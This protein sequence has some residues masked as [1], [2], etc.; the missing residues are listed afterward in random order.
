MNRRDRFNAAVAGKPVDR[1]PVSV[2]MHFVTQYMTGDKSAER[3]AQFFQHYNF[4]IAKAVS[5]YR[6]PLP[7]GM[8]SIE[9][10][11]D[12]NRIKKVPV[13]ARSFAEQ[14]NLLKGLRKR[15]GENWPVIDTFFD[16][17]QL[18]LR[19][20]G[21][22]TMTLILDNPGKAIPM[23][24]AATESI[25]GYVR[26]LKKIGVDGAFYSTRAAATES[27]SQGF[28]NASFKELLEPYDTA[29]LN[30]MKGMVRLLHT[31]KSHLDLSRVKDYP[32]E[33]LSWAD[34][35]PTCPT[36][37]QVRAT[38]DKCLMGGINQSG[39]IEQ[40]VNEIKRDIDS[41]ISI[42]NG[43]NFILSPGC[44]IGSNVPDHVL[45]TIAKY[46]IDPN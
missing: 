42:N 15:L 24:E 43:Q 41:A 44:T 40:N 5:D 18:V 23:I 46:A 11:G 13:T 22:S 34:R 38:S 45:A 27:S 12:F 4:D 39:V 6:F 37:A 17:I 35:D 20:A 32:H 25:I 26:E 16:P 36:M 7:D 1:V 33:V 3:H 8:L 19:R 14:L 30:E 28:S 2:W 29:I 10:V 9:T 21:F 31:C